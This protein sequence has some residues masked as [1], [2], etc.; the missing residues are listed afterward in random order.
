VHPVRVSG[1]VTRV[2]ETVG[3]SGTEE[4]RRTRR[5]GG[6]IVNG[7]EDGGSGNSE[8]KRGSQIE[9]TAMI[10][11]SSGARPGS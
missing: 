1:R 5:G 3:G 11:G 9:L 7:R 4:A 10:R 6:L 2:G 8:R